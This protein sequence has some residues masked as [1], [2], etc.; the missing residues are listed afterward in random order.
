MRP[1]RSAGRAGDA[2]A[3][4]VHRR[5]RPTSPAT[6]AAEHLRPPST[7]ATPTVGTARHRRSAR[8]YRLTLAAGDRARPTT[9]DPVACTGATRRRRST[10]AGSTPSS[11]ATALGRRLRHGCS[12]SWPTHCLPR[13]AASSAVRRRLARLSRLQGGLVQPDAR[14]V[15]RRRG[16]VP[17]R[18]DRV[19]GRRP[20]ARPPGADAGF[21]GS[22]DRPGAP[23]H[24]RPLRHRP[25]GRAGASSGSRARSRHSWG[26]SARSRS[27]AATATPGYAAVR[28]AGDEACSRTWS[29][30]AT[31]SRPEVRVRLGVADAASSGRPV[32]GTGSAGLRTRSPEPFRPCTAGETPPDRNASA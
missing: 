21:A 4:R 6:S 25:P 22:L 17:L 16:L 28:A 5:A 26:R 24:L 10:S 27:P 14:A 20:A 7:S 18:P 3:H 8:C 2:P 31:S 32:S 30:A 12:G 29:A 13:A 23:G 11:T 19:R 9:R 15:R 1:S